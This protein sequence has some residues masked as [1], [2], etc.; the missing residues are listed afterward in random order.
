MSKQSNRDR[1]ALSAV[2]RE[3]SGVFDR[4]QVPSKYRVGQRVL[5]APSRRK[6]TNDEQWVIVEVFDKPLMG[7]EPLYSIKSVLD[8]KKRSAIPEDELFAV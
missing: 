7:R 2:E 3:L 6:D 4:K 1:I 8:G 5:W